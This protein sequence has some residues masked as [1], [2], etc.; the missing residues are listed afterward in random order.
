MNICQLKILMNPSPYLLIVLHTQQNVKI[1]TD[2]LYI[3]LLPGLAYMIDH[4]IGN[5]SVTPITNN[6]FDVQF[7]KNAGYV[8]KMKNPLDLFYLNGSYRYAGQVNS[9][10]YMLL[11]VT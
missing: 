9:K 3:M 5:C 2:M 10:K 8:I 7:G 6:S 1:L 11:W 4:Q